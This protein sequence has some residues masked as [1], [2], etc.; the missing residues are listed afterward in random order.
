MYL[1]NFLSL[2]TAHAIFIAA[3]RFRTAQSLVGVRDGVN[4]T[5]RLPG[6]ERFVNNLP[7]S[8]IV[9]Y[10]NGVRLA[11]LDDY[12]AVES[13]GFGTGYDTVVLNEAPFA[14]DHL[15]ADYVVQPN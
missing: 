1:V 13:G 7:F 14:D 11:L 10:L 9:V 3:S 2:D 6:S 12:I 15:I 8:T 5:F 4:V